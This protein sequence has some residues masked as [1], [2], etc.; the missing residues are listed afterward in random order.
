M[1]IP[2]PDLDDLGYAD[3]LEEART[4]LPSFSPEWTNHNPSD[5]GITLVEL[6]AWLAEMLV[7]R[8]NQVP[9]ASVQSFLKLL[10]GPEW[11]G[12]G[13]LDE[14]VRA[15][16]VRLREAYR[17]VTPADYE[18]LAT[19]AFNAWLARVRD[20]EA[21]GGSLVEWHR[22]TRLPPGA[23]GLPSGVA[24][25]A[26][27]RC[28]PRRYLGA[29]SEAE[30]ARDM[31]GQVSV[32][33]VPRREDGPPPPLSGA[34][35]PVAA[36][37]TRRA[38]WGFLE[39][40]RLLGTRVHVMAPVY[41]PVRVEAVVIRRADVPDPA[42]P[43]TLRAS[44][45]RVAATDVRRGVLEA[46]A[47][48]LD[49]LLGGPGGEGWPFGRDVHVSDLYGVIEGVY[50]VDQVVDLR[51]SS[52]CPDGRSGC[53]AAAKVRHPETGEQVGLAL[54]AHHLP[55]ADL[56][57]EDVLV[58]AA[59]VPVRVRV[60]LTPVRHV[61]AAQLERAVSGAVR[62]VFHP[63]H[64]G[65]DGSALES[66]KAAVVSAAVRALP[67]VDDTRLV[68]VRFEAEPRRLLAPEDRDNQAVRIDPREIA[69]PELAL[70]CEGR[71]LWD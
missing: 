44:W 21:A 46:V 1:A 29:G 48:W 65:P 30:R 70:D 22:V 50:G 51:L 12:G 4:L 41:V 52:T 63:F 14:E 3:L 34:A 17:A 71:R 58:A 36:E 2:L 59:V 66:V 8:A 6:F 62:D 39:E 45:D 7:W 19:S 69:G 53:V 9:D 68:H 5:P 38:V 49:P 40:R 24:P 26:R 16:V 67:E 20:E 31:P 28:V 23:G 64:G 55:R 27:A 15:T 11:K 54:A 32:L 25:I 33:V 37:A 35:P 57:P 42:S 10:N 47:A 56:R 60:S 61:T 13:D 18:R 43:D